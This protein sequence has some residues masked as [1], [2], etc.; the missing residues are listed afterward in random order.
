MGQ[1]VSL[2][3]FS[4]K[5]VLITGGSRGIGYAVARGFAEAR[6]DVTILADDD[7]VF[8]AAERLTRE[9]GADVREIQCDITDRADVSR[10]LSQFSRIDVLIN[11]AGAERVTPIEEPGSEVEAAFRRIIDV[12]LLGPYYVTRDALPHMSNGSRILFTA[13][14]WGKTAVARLSAY[15]ASK[16]AVLGLMRSLAQ[17]LGPKKITVNAICPGFVRTQLSFSSVH[18]EAQRTRRSVDEIVDDLLR[19]QAIE[20]LLEPE[21]MISGYLFLAS[22]LAKDIT[23]QCLHIDRGE[24]MD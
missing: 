1:T 24:L 18:V 12:N 3:D 10:A 9:S 7:G 21:D 2:F 8:E 19:P 14:T 11:N 20:G 15:C 17:E 6:A 22:D 13:S 23:G 4:E 5:Q 16:H